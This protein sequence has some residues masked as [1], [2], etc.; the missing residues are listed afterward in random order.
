M[1]RMS[2]LGTPRRALAAALAAC[3]AS[4]MLM[5]SPGHASA[6]S[7]NQIGGFDEP[8]YVDDAPG[9]KNSRLLFVVEK[10]GKV[11]VLRNG[12]PLPAPFLDLTDM[13][14][15]GSEQ[16]LLSI[17]FHPRYE[18]NRL[19][20]AYLTDRNGDNAVYEFKRAGKSK[21][22]ALRASA[23][24]VLAIP[25]PDD[26]TNHNGGQL[27]F[28]RKGLLYIA[29][30]DG[31]STPDAAQDRNSLLGKVLRIDPVKQTP[32]KG[33][34]GAAPSAVAAY[35]IPAGNPFAGATAGR[36][37]IYALGLR[38]PFRFSFDSATG[39]LLIGDVGSSTREEL[40]YR[41]PGRAAG[42][43]FGWPRFEGT[44]LHDSGVQAPGA[45]PPI[46]EYPTGVN[47]TCVITGGYVVHDRR[48]ASLQGRYVYAD[49]CVGEIRSL[50][51]SEGGA[52]GDAPVGLPAV[53]D[54]SSFG[55]GRNGVIFVASLRGPVYR[56]DP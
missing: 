41:G 6:L 31:G 4:A 51:P 39:A 2:L 1:Q 37:E 40:D 20:Y 52:S 17:A 24:L 54:L 22:R 32:R 44:T 18:K 25:H 35:G 27:Q 42:A 48:L 5:L 28:D 8:V 7:L 19:L 3:A 34:K 46:F 14:G 33:K 13:V 55:E 43:N 15:N 11:Q 12:V 26:A 30:G 29:P 23:R 53:S 49:F 21:V 47:G 9:K 10:P 56:L 50:I 45:I 16:G 36:D 38:N